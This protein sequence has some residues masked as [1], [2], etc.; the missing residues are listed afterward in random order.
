MEYCLL[1]KVK[2][3]SKLKM[4]TYTSVHFLIKHILNGLNFALEDWRKKIGVIIETKWTK[5]EKWRE[6][7]A[8]HYAN[9]QNYEQSKCLFMIVQNASLMF[10]VS[11]TI[12]IRDVLL[13]LG[14]AT[15]K[16]QEQHT[17]SRAN[18]SWWN[19]KK[20]NILSIWF[21]NEFRA[22]ETNGVRYALSTYSLIRSLTPTGTHVHNDELG[23]FRIEMMM[24]TQDD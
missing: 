9:H 11:A 24:Y 13:I 22:L 12:Y 8:K 16:K 18:K 23:V 3:I 4:K 19:R 1:V 5:D 7:R 17:A 6:E 10:F 14:W 2:R 20:R 15:K 21:I